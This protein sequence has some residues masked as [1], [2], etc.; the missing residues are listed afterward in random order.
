VEDVNWHTDCRCVLVDPRKLPPGFADAMWNIWT[1][2]QARTKTGGF[3]ET[4]AVMRREWPNLIGDGVFPKVPK[5]L[6]LEMLSSDGKIIEPLSQDRWEQIL[7]KHS[8][9]GTK[10]DVAQQFRGM[11]SSEIARWIRDAIEQ[12]EYYGN[13]YPVG[14]NNWNYRWQMPDGRDGDVALALIDGEW[15]IWT[16]FPANLNKPLR[17]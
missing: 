17:S 8:P 10:S 2:C 12:S 13:P 11:S 16:A 15:K 6:D 14:S 4:L 7:R 9:G 3:K 1:T 5:I